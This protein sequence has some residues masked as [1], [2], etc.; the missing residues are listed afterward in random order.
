[1]AYIPEGGYYSIEGDVLT[2]S[3][4]EQIGSEFKN[5]IVIGETLYLL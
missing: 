1:M 4:N 5:A 3:S 2:I